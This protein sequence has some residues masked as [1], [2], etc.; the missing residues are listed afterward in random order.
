MSSLNI[1]VKTLL[2]TSA[3]TAIV[4]QRV[5][6][7]F[8]PQNAAFPHIVVYLVAEDEEDLLTGAS[9]LREGRVTIESR[10]AGDVPVL[11]TLGEAVID[12]MRDR[13]E[14]AI[15]SCIVTTRKAG[16]DETDAS[17]QTNAQGYPS[18]VRRITDFYLFWR[19]A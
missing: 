7:I 13:V 6:P 18:V 11:A 9:Q 8:A 15:A 2:A 14:Y 17:D 3:V 1:A 10:T 19:K 16:T 4:G 5:Y 12:A